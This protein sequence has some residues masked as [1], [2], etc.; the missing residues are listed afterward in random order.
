[1]GGFESALDGI[2]N[3]A[4]SLHSS[5]GFEIA[6]W[7]LAGVLIWSGVTKLLHPWKAALAMVDF[8]VV[9]TPSRKQGIALGVVELGLGALLALGAVTMLSLATALV[10]FSAFT[11]L[12]ARSLLRGESFP[13]Q[14]FGG[15]DSRLGVTSLLRAALLMGLCGLLLAADQATASRALDSWDT[16]LTLTVAGSALATIVLCAQVPHLLGW[17]GETVEHLRAQG[18]EA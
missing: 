4:S 3:A 13:C 12:I 6:T 2:G 5:P 14:C 16:Y 8:G 7:F 18:E 9:K 11:V 1:M 15:D 17:N 10:L